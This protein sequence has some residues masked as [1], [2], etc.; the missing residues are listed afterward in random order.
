MK[1]IFFLQS[2]FYNFFCLFYKIIDI[3]KGVRIK[4]LENEKKEKIRKR[5][6]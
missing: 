1:K 4:K 3:L 2:S 6:Y 5:T